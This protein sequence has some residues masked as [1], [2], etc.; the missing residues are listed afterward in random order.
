MIQKTKQTVCVDVEAMFAYEEKV[1]KNLT[2]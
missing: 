1:E 2:V